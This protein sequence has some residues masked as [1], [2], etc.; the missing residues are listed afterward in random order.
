MQDKNDSIKRSPDKLKRI[1][2]MDGTVE[3]HHEQERRKE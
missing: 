1:I 3:G 2:R